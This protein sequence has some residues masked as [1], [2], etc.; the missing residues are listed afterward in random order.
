[1]NR[2]GR[3]PGS[4]NK[5]APAAAGTPAPAP[6]PE[7]VVGPPRPGPVPGHK[8]AN[9]GPADFGPAP[10]GSAAAPEAVLSGSRADG[11]I[12]IRGARQHNLKNVSVD[13]PRNSLTVISGLSGSGK[14]SLAF[15]TLYAEGQRR[16][17]ESLSSYA[18]QFLGQMDKPDVDLIEGLSPAISIEQK[19]TSKNPRSTVGTVTEIYDYLRLLYARVGAA[20]CHLCGR[21]IRPQS[22]SEIVDRLARLPKGTRIAILAP[23]VDAR[24]G[25][26]QKLFDRLRKSGYT[27]ARVGGRMVDLSEEIS[28]DKKRR[29][30][31]EVVMDRLQIRDGLERRLA[32]TVESGLKESEGSL[33]VLV[34]DE[35]NKEAEELFFSERFACSHCGVS[36]PELSPQLFSFNAPQGACPHCDGL[37]ADLF[38]DPDL[39]IPDKDLSLMEGAVAPWG[40]AAGGY[41]LGQLEGVFSHYGWD[42]RAPVKNLPE[43]ALEVTLRGTG[44]QQIEFFFERDGRRYSY[45]KPFEGVLNCLERRWKETDSA[46]MKDELEEYITYQ[47]CPSCGGARLKPEALAVLVAGKSI[48]QVCEMTVAGSLDFFLHIDLTDREQAIGRRIVKEI[49]ERLGFLNDVGLGYL[50]LSR[51]S[52]TLSG[53]ESQRIRLATQIGSKLVGVMYVLDEP[54]IGLHQRDNEKL[55]ASLKRMRDLGNT[56]VVV[57]HDAEAIMAADVILDLGPGAGERGGELVFQGTPERLVAEHK[58]LTGQ[59][60]AGLIEVGTPAR[61]RP[62]GQV[63]TV[64]GARGH[65]LK[66]IDVDFPLGVLTCVTGV[67][68]SGKS[69][70]VL[71]TLYKALARKISRSRVRPAPHDDIVGLRLVDKVVDI[72]QSPIGR[73]P[74]SNPA[75]YAGVFTPVRELFAQL[76][77]SRARG[78]APGRF[79]FNVKGGRCEKCQGDGIIRI[80]MH[81]LPDVYVKCESCQ[82]LRYNRDTLE[83]RYAG[84]SIADVLNMTVAEAAA[85]FTNI[86]SLRD[87]LLTL[88]EVGLGYVRL[89]QSATTLSGGEAQRVKLSKELSRRDTG[90]TVYILDEPTTGLHFDD[91]R[92]LLEVLQRLVGQGNTVIVIE[93]NLDVVKN[94][95]HVIDLGPEGGDGGGLVVAEGTPEQ[96]AANPKSHTG[97][98][99]KT[100]LKRGGG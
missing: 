34:Y 80:E 44:R 48:R 47:P 19:T 21:P 17:V 73:T 6:G 65:N 62:A 53:G 67:S 92:K 30:E 5:A 95:D 99:L 24:K 12:T 55:I 97:R 78:Y 61:R 43:K 81:F 66:N 76:P 82:G 51:S 89:G 98:Y 88:Q 86:P 77:E 7:A 91:V 79:S 42:F 32:D 3:P 59:Y 9:S 69:T 14:S 57:E 50:T 41:Y 15:D 11:A 37:G 100:V 84:A 83:V 20:H 36:F 26:H 87:K 35:N 72:D 27:R 4:K 13:I 58:T 39:V 93:H 33:K 70:L 74:R 49:R 96:V 25:E 16:Y 85:F 54:S 10:P 2:R 31:I 18:R 40:R 68:G 71:E 63:V 52:S 23:L 60:L 28:L 64:K 29:H 56:V 45:K 94:A 46:S 22:P 38:F 8:P 1:M 75:T 90:R